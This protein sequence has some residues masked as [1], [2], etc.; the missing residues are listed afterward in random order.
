MLVALIFS[1]LEKRILP[2]Q[3]TVGGTVLGLVLSPFVPP[4]DD[5]AQALLWLVGIRSIHGVWVGISESVVGAL[6]PAFCLFMIGF[7]YEKAK[8][9]E[10]LGL[11]DVKLVA[12]VGS[13]LG[14]GGALFMLV[15]GS[16]SGSIIGMAYIKLAHKDASDYPLPFGTFLAGSALAAALMGSGVL[17]WYSGL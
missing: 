15:L 8:K 1:D 14:L 7:L 2:D 12:M 4:P 10:A 3:F 6:V 11:G 17:G 16:L 5:T 13:F 9:K